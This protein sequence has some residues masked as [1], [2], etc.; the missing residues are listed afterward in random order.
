MSNNSKKPSQTKSGLEFGNL[1]RSRRKELKMSVRVVAQKLG[2][3]ASHYCRM[4]SGVRPRLGSKV[5]PILSETLGI[6]VSVLQSFAYKKEVSKRVD[7][8]GKFLFDKRT[9]QN[10]SIRALAALVGVSSATIGFYESGRMRPSSEVLERI[11]RVLKTEIPEHLIPKKVK[12]KKERKFSYV[13]FL[14]S[15]DETITDLS[16][17]REMTGIRSNEEVIQWLLKL[18]YSPMFK[19]YLSE[20]KS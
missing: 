20:I 10:M 8:M 12:L 19:S 5:I 11:V 17:I 15:D 14:L 4:E 1:I 9:K 2:V 13:T 3:S 16:R 18:Q 6:E 7:P